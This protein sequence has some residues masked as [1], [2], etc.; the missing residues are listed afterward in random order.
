MSPRSDRVGQRRALLRR[1]EHPASSCGPYGPLTIV[2]AP[3]RSQL[4]SILSGLGDLEPVTLH[5][6]QECELDDLL[7]RLVEIGYSRADLVGNRG[8]IAVRGGIVD[9]FPPTEEH[10]FRID[11]FGDTIDEIRYCKVAVPRII[12]LG[13]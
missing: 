3:V 9:V 12:G 4:H 5:P 13:K 7:T 8:E 10:P 1:I 2:V 6:G 11:L